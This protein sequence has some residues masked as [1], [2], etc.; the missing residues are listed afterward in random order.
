MRAAS[1]SDASSQVMGAV[2]ADAGADAEGGRS[3]IAA[4]RA[5]SRQPGCIEGFCKDAE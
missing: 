2:A 4:L 1:S 5:T 3:A